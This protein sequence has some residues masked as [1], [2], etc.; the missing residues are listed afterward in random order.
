MLQDFG[1]SHCIYIYIPRCIRISLEANRSRIWTFGL[2]NWNWSQGLNYRI[3]VK[4]PCH[5]LKEHW[6]WKSQAAP[7]STLPI[8]LG[9]R[10]R[11]KVAIKNVA[12]IACN[13]HKAQALYFTYTTATSATSALGSWMMVNQS[14]K[15][16]HTAMEEI[17]LWNVEMFIKPSKECETSF[18]LILREHS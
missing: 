15:I 3:E 2:Q 6:S 16:S 12:Q 14:W 10:L 5:L 11:G 18:R 17:Q 9:G 7:Y 8:L 13:Y 1:N 4:C